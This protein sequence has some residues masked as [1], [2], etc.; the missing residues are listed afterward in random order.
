M[1]SIRFEFNIENTPPKVVIYN[2]EG[3]IIEMLEEPTSHLGKNVEIS[4]GVYDWQG[5]FSWEQEDW[6][7]GVIA[8]KILKHLNNK[9]GGKK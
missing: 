6:E 7:A 2:D 3:A 1:Y 4:P 8:K 5:E 9:Q